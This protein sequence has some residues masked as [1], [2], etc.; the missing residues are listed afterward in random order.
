MVTIDYSVLK[1]MGRTLDLVLNLI[2]EILVSFMQS[3]F[4]CI[5][6]LSYF[7]NPHEIVFIITAI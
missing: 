5:I 4:V 2:V 3:T 1:T 6:Y 7:M